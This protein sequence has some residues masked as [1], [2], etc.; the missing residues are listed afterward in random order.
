MDT[1]ADFEKYATKYMGKN[2]CSPL[3]AMEAAI[4]FMD[5]PVNPN[6][7]K[8]AMQEEKEPYDKVAYM[9]QYMRDR[10]AAAKV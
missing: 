5:E 8:A 6:P 10:R 3:E 9:R 2:G 1:I 4:E 7:L